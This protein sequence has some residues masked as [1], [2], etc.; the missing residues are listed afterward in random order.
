M[1]LRATLFRNFGVV[2]LGMDCR[3]PLG[4]TETLT[5]HRF[6]PPISSVLRD[7]MRSISL[8]RT[9]APRIGAAAPAI[10]RALNR[11]HAAGHLD[12]THLVAE[13]P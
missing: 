11:V 2:V 12:Q 9:L 3:S 4:R 8:R 5:T 10:R 1:C 6:T 7:A 13:R